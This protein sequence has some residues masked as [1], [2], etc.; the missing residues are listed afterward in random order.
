M[1]ATPETTSRHE[2]EIGLLRAAIVAAIAL[3]VI[4]VAAIA[5]GWT[6]PAPAPFDLTPNPGVDLPV[7]SLAGNEGAM[8]RTGKRAEVAPAVGLEPTTWRLTA[9]RS[10]N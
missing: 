4:L 7:Q 5:F 2:L 9:A 3:A 6:L 10:T 1:A 8:P